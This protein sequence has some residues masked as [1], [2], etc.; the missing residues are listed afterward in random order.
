MAALC[1]SSSAYGVE[2][3]TPKVRT[4]QFT[5]A[6]TVIGLKPGQMARIWLPV[7]S[8][9]PA[10]DLEMVSKDLPVA[11]RIEKE[12]QYGNRILY[13]EAK[14][15]DKGAI[16]VCVVYR[17]KRR[18][19]KGTTNH[20]TKDDAQQL[21]RFL[22]PNR[23]VPIEGKPLDLLKGKTLPSD[24]MALARVCYDVVKNHMRY[25]KHGIGW[26]N[27]DSVWACEQGYGNCSDFHSLFI[28]LARS[29]HIPAKFEIGFPLPAK[30]G[31]GAIAGYHCWA[32]FHLKDKGWLPVDISEAS[33]NPQQ[34]DYYFGNLTENRVAFSTGRDLE[35]VPKQAGPPLN[36]FIYP[37]VE[38]DG[39]VYSQT[40]I[41]RR[42][43]FRDER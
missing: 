27:G 11:G 31:S 36:F 17:I 8:S 5:Y 38:V 20:A 30:H 43:S 26:G 12:K 10:Q 9:G 18:E 1:L 14:A 39:K 25:S 33:K 23:R 34:S 40:K 19:V 3:D 15:N 42:F 7:P 13:L 35:L 29:R 32:E 2:K 41:E 16:P 6:A 37:Y 22:Q 4:F 24:E 28:S 21:K